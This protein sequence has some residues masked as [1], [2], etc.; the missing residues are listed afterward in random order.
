[1]AIEA[2]V[3]SVFRAVVAPEFGPGSRSE[4]SDDQVL[5]IIRHDL[6]TCTL[7][8]DEF[9]IKYPEAVAEL[10]AHRL[11]L[12]ARTAYSLPG[13]AAPG[14]VTNVAVRGHSSSYTPAQ[15]PAH[16][17]QDDAWRQTT[18]GI[19]LRDECVASFGVLC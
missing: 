16:S 6:T 14:P 11:T 4:R 17:H 13:F 9:G 5:A 19:R 3:L 7:D 1:M 2:L 18:H 10:A 8:E 15:S 12:Q